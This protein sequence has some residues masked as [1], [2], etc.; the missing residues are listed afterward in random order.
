MGDLNLLS[1]TT[2]FNIVQLRAVRRKKTGLLIRYEPQIIGMRR[3]YRASVFGSK[4]IVTAVVYESGQSDQWRETVRKASGLRHP[5]IFQLFGTTSSEHGIAALIYHDDFVA[6]TEARNKIRKFPL[7]S[8]YLEYSMQKELAVRFVICPSLFTQYMSVRM[9]AFTGCVLLANFLS[10]MNTLPGYVNKPADYV[11]MFHP[12]L[13]IAP[14]L[15][16]LCIANMDDHLLAQSFEL[17]DIHIILGHLPRW[18]SMLLTGQGHVS[19]GSVLVF[20]TR[21]DCAQLENV[22]ELARLPG[23]KINVFPWD[24]W[25]ADFNANSM[26]NGWTRFELPDRAYGVYHTKSSIKILQTAWEQA[27]YA[28]LSQANHIFSVLHENPC[29]ILIKDIKF[30]LSI[31]YPEDEYTLDGTFM[32]GTFPEQM[33]LFVSPLYVRQV[34]PP[35]EA[36]YWSLDPL[37]VERLTEDQAETFRVP[38]ISFAARL[39]G[40]SWTED[41]YEALQ[42]FYLDKGY[43]PASLDAVNQLGCPLFEVHREQVVVS[44]QGDY[45]TIGSLLAD[46]LCIK[47]ICRRQPKGTDKF[48]LHI[49]LE[50]KSGACYVLPQAEVWKHPVNITKASSRP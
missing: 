2:H 48:C 49:R 24:E 13:K 16:M 44:S 17:A 46:T 5:N 32:A 41:H 28:W 39:W 43:N 42:H 7:A 31:W 33:Y 23:C 20:E 38:N 40:C 10:P 35:N 29:P 15:S 9:P 6:V 34:P 30:S 19:V 26:S 3:T 14:N 50:M 1:E 37:G 8:C 36:F 4:H 47:E 11:S 12:L 21:T 18:E 25:P 27:T 22:F 45:M